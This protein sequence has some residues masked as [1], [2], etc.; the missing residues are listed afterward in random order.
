ML[1]WLTVPQAAQA[2][3]APQ[4][5]TVTFQ[6]GSGVSF[7]GAMSNLVVDYMMFSP[8][9]KPVRATA[10]V[11]IKALPATPAPTNPTSGGVSGRTSKQLSDG[12][13]LASIAYKHYGDPNLWRAIA[14]ANGI[15]DPARVPLGTWLL[16]PPR[17]EAVASAARG[18]EHA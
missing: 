16:M 14:V 12:D 4:P 3:N 2:Q 8:S 7:A 15:D 9:G 5:A 10:T 18:A 11:T 17:N 1:N 13:S 6:W